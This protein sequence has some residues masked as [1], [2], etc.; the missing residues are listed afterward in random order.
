MGAQMVCVSRAPVGM[1]TPCL[2]E[3]PPALTGATGPLGGSGQF[4][5]VTFSLLLFFCASFYTDL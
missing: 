4:H 2:V 1:V 5:A 3:A